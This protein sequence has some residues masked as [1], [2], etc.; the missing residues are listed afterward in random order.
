MIAAADQGSYWGSANTYTSVYR[1]GLA[2]LRPVKRDACK[3]GFQWNVGG[4][5]LL[6]INMS[7]VL[8]C[9]LLAEGGVLFER[10]EV[11][12]YI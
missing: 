3:S 2:A 4:L 1:A 9:L 12:V 11:L 6:S 7:F 10:C 8:F 5:Y